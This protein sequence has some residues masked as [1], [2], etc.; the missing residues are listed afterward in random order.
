MGPDSE[1]KEKES[2]VFY[3]SFFAKGAAFVPLCAINNSHDASSR[4]WTPL[5]VESSSAVVPLAA[6]RGPGSV[7]CCAKHNNCASQVS[8]WGMGANANATAAAVGFYLGSCVNTSFSR[9]D[10]TVSLN[11]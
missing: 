5:F 8:H 11:K 7:D 4:V 6:L 10:F 2:S 3:L 1:E 9:L